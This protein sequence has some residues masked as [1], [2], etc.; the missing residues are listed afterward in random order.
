[1][2]WLGGSFS[3]V[4][5]PQ[6][7]T[8]LQTPVAGVVIKGLHIKSSLARSLNEGMEAMEYVR[9]GIFKPHI[10]I[11]MFRELPQV[12]EKLEKGE[13]SERIAF[14]IADD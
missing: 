14:Q 12:Y 3:C 10:Q 6:G 5:I 11:M 13:A 4:G 7:K 2:L 8:L 9:K 1:M